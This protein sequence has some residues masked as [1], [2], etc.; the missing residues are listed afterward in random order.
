MP[1]YKRPQPI[2]GLTPETAS[3]FE[4]VS[5]LECVKG[6]Y[7]CGGT[8]QSLQT[9]HRLSEDLDFEILGVRRERPQLDISGIIDE[10]TS[11]FD[12]AKP[13]ILSESHIEIYVTEA[14]VKLS[15]FRPGNPVKH[16]HEGWRHNNI[17]APTPQ[18]LLGMKVYTTGMRLLFRDYYDIYCLLKEGCDLTQAISYASYLSRHQM[19]S[20]SMYSRLLSPSLFPKNKEFARMSP[21]YDVSPEEIGEMIRATMYRESQR[22]QQEKEPRKGP[23]L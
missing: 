7:L 8:A 10:V 17:K 13:E 3:I 16:I 1:P 11:K 15:F 9:G 12:K 6:L 21:R 23:R 22:A 18:D 19:K 4:T 2:K 14:M 20:K 5:R